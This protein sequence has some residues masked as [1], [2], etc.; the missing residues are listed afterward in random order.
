M[1]FTIKRYGVTAKVTA[2]ARATIWAHHHCMKRITT[3]PS[4][5]FD[6]LEEV[7]TWLRKC[8]DNHRFF[9]NNDEATMTQRD[10]AWF[11]QLFGELVEK[12]EQTRAPR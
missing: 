3:D 5:C 10:H 2:A 4:E 1:I 9:A 8:A 6:P 11:A 12:I 7:A